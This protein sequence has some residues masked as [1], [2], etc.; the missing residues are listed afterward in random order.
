[1][2]CLLVKTIFGR[3][4]LD[5][6]GNPT[7]EV[8]INGFSASVPSGASTGKHE[9]V[10]LRDG[11]PRYNGRGVLKAVANVNKI[12]APK[13]KGKNFASQAAFD[14][15]LLS[16]DGTTNKSRLGA[17][18]ILGCSIAFLKA[19]G[20]LPTASKLAKTKPHL[21]VPASNLINGGM[22]AAG[23]AGIQEY[24]ILPVGI[25]KT[26]ERVRAVSEV[27]HTLKKIIAAKYGKANANIGDE[28]GFVPFS[29]KN[30]HEPLELISRSIEDCG[31]A[32]KISL[33]IDAAATSF[34]D[35]GRYYLD[36]V[37]LSVP[38]LLDFYVDLQK[39]FRLLYIEDPFFE[40]DFVSFALLTKKIGSRALVVG[41]DL[42]TTSPTRIK[43][44]IAKRACNCLLLK[45]NQIGTVTEAVEA[46]LIA[47]KAGWKTCVSHRSGETEDAFLAD[48]A[49]GIAADFI[50]LGAPC[51]GER[52]A[53]YNE[54]LRLAE[55]LE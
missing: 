50:K 46:H 30:S 54:L 37:A 34:F 8:E 13:I 18:A 21:P 20:V 29:V 47:K 31:Y 28:G 6:R 40:E 51:R 44:G 16:L 25:K 32:G 45:P 41:D 12:I 11:G 10:E 3:E 24:L 17:N 39:T 14:A 33:G 35:K 7:V 36:G 27:Y 48:F 38:Q 52:T 26:S 42:L 15:F 53:K 49:T 9:A 19:Q 55:Q 5:S 1:V 43:T 2:V 23:G 4:I 22:H